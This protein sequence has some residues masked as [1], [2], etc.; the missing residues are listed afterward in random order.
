MIKAYNNCY[1]SM[2]S[3]KNNNNNLISNITVLLEIVD[4]Q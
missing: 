4:F 2:N 1:L 3:Q